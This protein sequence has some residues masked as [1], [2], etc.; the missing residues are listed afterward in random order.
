MALKYNGEINP[1][2][3]KQPRPINRFHGAHNL[4]GFEAY[5]GLG[6]AADR[7]IPLGPDKTIL[8]AVW[9]AGR[10]LHTHDVCVSHGR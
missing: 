6:I 9:R 7:N 4:P 3:T 10:H 2:L 1:H 8:E 5:L